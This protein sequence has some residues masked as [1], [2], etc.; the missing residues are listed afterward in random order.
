MAPAFPTA[1]PITLQIIDLT[2]DGKIVLHDKQ[3]RA[4]LDKVRRRVIVVER[5]CCVQPSRIIVGCVGIKQH[6][7]EGI[8][9]HP[10][11]SPRVHNNPQAVR[12]R[13]VGP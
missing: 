4:I 10:P 9:R 13:A 5:V 1:P 6:D 12:S 8:R 2:D 3:L 7:Q 11:P